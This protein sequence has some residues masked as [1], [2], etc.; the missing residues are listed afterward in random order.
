VF[1][2]VAIGKAEPRRITFE[3]ATD[4]T[5]KTCGQQHPQTI[6]HDRRT[7]GV[8]RGRQQDQPRWSSSSCRSDHGVQEQMA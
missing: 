8:G 2:D 1:F 4:V 5:P 6:R 3:L 7:D